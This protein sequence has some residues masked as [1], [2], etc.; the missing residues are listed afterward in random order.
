MNKNQEPK[1]QDRTNGLLYLEYKRRQWAL[2]KSRYKL[3]RQR[4]RLRRIED[5]G[6]G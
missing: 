5:L 1:E 4:M 2:Q 3:L 6:N